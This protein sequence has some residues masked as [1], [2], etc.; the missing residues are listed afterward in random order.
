MAD[1]ERFGP[2]L[3]VR[4]AV[5]RGWI[6]AYL[7]DQT[8]SLLVIS[9]WGSWSHRWSLAGMP[10]GRT[11][12]EF[13]MRRDEWSYVAN[14]MCI[15]RSEWDETASKSSARRSLKHAYRRGSFVCTQSDY[16]DWVRAVRD[17]ATYE[18]LYRLP[19]VCDL[20]Y[21]T[22]DSSEL[23]LLRDRILPAIYAAYRGTAHA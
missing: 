6:H 3:R 13:I 9:D 17:A 22:M 8:C 18:E 2:L 5:D 12:T 23:V 7:D 4:T 10:D 14:K 21:I 19:F 20:D 16:A 11:F 1:V 15:T